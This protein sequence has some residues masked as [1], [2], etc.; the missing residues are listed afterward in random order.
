M[1]SDKFFIKK[2]IENKLLTTIKEELQK[3]VLTNERD[4]EASIYHHLRLYLKKKGSKLRLA[5][6][7][8]IKKFKVGHG[9]TSFRQPDIVILKQKQNPRPLIAIE[10]KQKLTRNNLLREIIKKDI[11]KL[12]RIRKAKIIE[13]GYII[14]VT[15]NKS[16][17]AKELKKR[18]KKLI[19]DKKIKVLIINPI[20]DYFENKL[21]MKEY[22]QKLKTFGKYNHLKEK[23]TKRIRR[24]ARQKQIITLGTKRMSEIAIKS[25]KKR[26][27]NK[28]K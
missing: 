11:K 20:E 7:F 12:E 22:F 19:K 26:K 8:T 6:N 5:T 10:I 13:T 16:S 28:H 18:S 14:F 23:E 27:Q 1:V 24:Q 21:K 3:H 17:Y 9:Q 4:I 25:A 15:N 2:Y